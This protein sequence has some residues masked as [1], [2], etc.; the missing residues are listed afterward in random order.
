[1]E[2]RL[3]N[4]LWSTLGVDPK[5][6]PNHI[7]LGELGI[8]SMIAVELQQNLER[9]YDIKLTLNQ[10]K[11]ITVKQMKDFPSGNKEEMSRAAKDFNTAKANLTKIKFIIPSEKYT[12]LNNALDGNPIYSIYYLQLK[13]YSLPL[14]SWLKKLIDL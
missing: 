14:L 12:K 8:E 10:I 9:E 7:T 2:E 6:L 13:E 4:Q 11:K 1:L 3:I 5:T